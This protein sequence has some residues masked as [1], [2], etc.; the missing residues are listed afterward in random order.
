[1][2][3]TAILILAFAAV[4]PA[5][6]ESVEFPWNAYPRQ[7]W[8]R[9]LAWLKNIG[10]GHV[11]LPPADSDADKARLAEAIQIVRRLDLEADLEGPVPDSMMP[12]MRAHG[13]PLTDALPGDAVRLSVL[14][15]TALTRSRDIL[16]SGASGLIWT[17]VE[18]RL[19]SD[20][21]HAGG[22]NFAGQERAATNGLR[23]DAFLSVYWA[24]TFPSLREVPGLRNPQMPGVPAGVS[25]RQF[26]GDT[27]IS[28]V[29]VVNKSAAP[30][31]GEVKA[32]YPALKRTI[33]IT[34]SVPANDA[35]WLPV[36]LPLMAGALCKDCSAFAAADH[37]VYATAE[38]TAMEYENGILAMEFSAP[39]GGEAVLQLS[40]E[41]FGPYMAGGRPT[42]FDWDANEKRARLKIPQG[43]GTGSRV[44]VGLA[45]EAPDATAFFDNARVLVIGETN[46]IPAKFSSEEIAGRSR[47]RITPAFAVKQE[48]DKDPLAMT[49]SIAVPATAAH[50]DH[51]EIAIEADGIQ[52][53][54][55]RVQLLRAASLRFSDSIEVHLAG[56]SALPLSPATVPVNQRAGREITV[57][58]RNNA[59]EIRNFHFEIAAVGLDFSPQKVDV[60]VGASSARDLTFRVFA[61]GAAAGVHAGT[62]TLSGAASVTEP[63]QFVVIPQGGSA[64]YSAGDFSLLES[65]R[66]RAAFLPGRWL[67]LMDK[68]NDQNLLPE[69][70]VP[71]TTEQRN[72]SRPEDLLPLAPKSKR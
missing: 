36:S 66:Y 20:G 25:I 41:P 63:V 67:E 35:V 70:G 6:V 42:T 40:R 39:S 28:L 33:G 62:A 45:I 72:I 14:D 12:L 31:T 49:Y 10:I 3:R 21:Y 54:H 51:A 16:G 60:S 8:E 59:P 29:S 56:N 34:V 5:W 43:A 24:K 64:S 32:L 30:W 18:D 46:R 38:L 1:M 19:A 9:E 11:S 50:G 2:I 23:R 17:D 13:G 7:L 22:V 71:A 55:A 4:S 27:G 47:L 53:T 15:K 52:M 61:Q 58:V 37:L 44:R 69:S 57:S 65:A 26:L 48:P 68:D